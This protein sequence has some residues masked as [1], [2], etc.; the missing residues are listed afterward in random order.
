MVDRNEY[1]ER[2]DQNEYGK[3]YSNYYDV[4]TN[5]LSHHDYDDPQAYSSG[6]SSERS[7]S[8]DDGDRQHSSSFMITV[9][10]TEPIDNNYQAP[11]VPAVQIRI[12][13]NSQ[14]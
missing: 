10:M 12:I 13:T 4:F 11:A 2:E 5:P 1:Y 14:A 8:S 7:Q 3:A 6:G 9:T